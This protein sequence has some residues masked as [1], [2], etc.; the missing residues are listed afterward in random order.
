M[1]N[2]VNDIAHNYEGIYKDIDYKTFSVEEKSFQLEDH[3]LG[4]C[5]HLAEVNKLTGDMSVNVD[6]LLGIVGSYVLGVQSGELDEN[7]T[8][9]PSTLFKVSLY[10]TLENATPIE[11]EVIGEEDEL[12]YTNNIEDIEGHAPEDTPDL[13]A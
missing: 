5:N 8:E 6:Y 1:S 11:A 7:T 13:R 4:I 9:P 10:P 12:D 2:T 3:L